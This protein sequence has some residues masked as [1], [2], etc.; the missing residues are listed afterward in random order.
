MAHATESLQTVWTAADLV[1]RFGPIPLDRIRHDPAPGTAAENDVIEIHDREDRLYELV[2]GVL[3][4]KTVGA[5]ES[6]LAALLIR[7][8]GNFVDDKNLGIVL[9]ADGMMR[10]APGLVRIP[11]VS[12]ISWDRLPNRQV[13]R[14]PIAE[15]APDLAVEV[16]SKSNTRKEMEDKLVDYFDATVRLV[17]YVYPETRQV[18]V[19]VAPD[20]H[21]L[22]SEDQILDCGEVLPG[23]SLQLRQYFSE[24]GQTAETK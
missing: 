10:L 6:Y 2:D 14:T 17:W 12:F 15:L 16:I 8:I 24:P 11:D 3:V 23:F 9:G 1:E 19:Y 4:E 22:L 5:Y 18:R 13:P 20:Q 21:S 7:R